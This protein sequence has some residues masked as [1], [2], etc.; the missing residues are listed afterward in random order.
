M[1][2]CPNDRKAVLRALIAQLP[3]EQK[4]GFLVDYNDDGELQTWEYE[5]PAGGGSNSDAASSGGSKD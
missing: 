5:E 4:D 1:K 3:D 2:F